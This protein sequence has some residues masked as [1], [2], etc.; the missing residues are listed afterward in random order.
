MLDTPQPHRSRAELDHALPHILAAPKEAG[1]VDL[2]VVRPGKGARQTPDRIALSAAGG[3]AG[4]HWAA[5]CWLS[6]DDG[7]PHPDVQ[8]CMMM[9]RCIGAIA[10][11]IE[12]WAPAGDNLFVDMDLT[13]ANMPPGTRFSLGTADLVVTAVPHNG[14]RKFIER[15]GRDACT[16]VNTG[17]GREH[18][19]RGIYARVIRDGEL[20]VGDSLK[21]RS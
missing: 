4:D 8:I 11:S 19:L 16:F 18:R 3:V 1:R 2:I 13:P 17:K 12:H 7:N 14:C 21:K 5:G 9:S 6:D 15:F 20:A 10:G